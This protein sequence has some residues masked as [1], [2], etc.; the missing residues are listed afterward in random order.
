MPDTMILYG[1]VVAGDQRR[2]FESSFGDLAARITWLTDRSPLPSGN[3]PLTVIVDLDNP[4][5]AEPEFLVSVAQSPGPVR[6]IGKSSAPSMQAALETARF[7]VAEILTEA[8]CLRRLES[9]LSS[10]EAK[11]E[12]VPV[13]SST[14][15]LAAIVGK[16]ESMREI[17][18]TVEYLSEV[19]F[20]S[21]L[22]LGET[23][24]GK[25]LI[26]KVL[27]TTGLRA[28]F[29]L[30]E[31]NCSAIPD[32]LF[33]SEL[34]GH[35]KGA[36]TDAKIEKIG[37]FEFA[38][39][40][41]LFLDEVGNLSLSAQAKLLKVLED[42]KL[43][44]V[45]DIRERDINVRVVAA[46]NCDLQRAIMAGKFREDL[47]FRLNL[48]TIELP[49]VRERLDDLSEMVGHFLRLYSTIYAKPDIDLDPSAVEDMKQYYWPGN[50]R[51][52]SNVVERAVLLAKG[53]LIHARDINVVLKNGRVTARDRQHIT[54]DLP[55]QGISL[56]DIEA[57]VALQVLNMF[58][59]NKSE[60]AAYLKTSRPRLRRI[61]ERAGLEQN[62]RGH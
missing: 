9:F 30:V 53:K 29:N 22:I 6:L 42:K 15:S 54:I 16:S 60:A 21:A 43:R 34:F 13:K 20:P 50:V 27:H 23:G 19:D 36:F 14:H 40:G 2:R 46:T 8:Q 38:Q 32:E 56:E 59:W 17:R 52:L 25:S 18:R 33:E 48:L 37:L 39:N 49:P 61:I 55:D 3:G 62:R 58:N 1:E 5:F 12:P 31:V 4:S 47:Y 51:E 10:L 7:G 11:P 24:T 28:N 57:R 44:K 26:C 35:A 41:T 45:G